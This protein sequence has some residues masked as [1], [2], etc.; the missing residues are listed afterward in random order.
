VQQLFGVRAVRRFDEHTLLPA[1]LTA[2]QGASLPRHLQCS[3]QKLEQ[4][5][6]GGAFDGSRVHADLERLSMR[7]RSFGPFRSRLRAHVQL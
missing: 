5:F 3:G 1:G 2:E 7:A 6:V 4:R